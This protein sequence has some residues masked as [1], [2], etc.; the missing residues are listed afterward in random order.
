[1]L[2]RLAD[3]PED[4]AFAM[5]KTPMMPAY[6]NAH[7]EALIGTIIE[8]IGVE[9]FIEMTAYVLDQRGNHLAA[10]YFSAL[11]PSMFL[12]KTS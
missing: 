1:M 5:R 4:A 9:R 11:R 12:E 3:R 8:R 7:W 10:E 2:D 6:D